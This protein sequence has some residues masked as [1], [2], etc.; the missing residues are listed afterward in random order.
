MTVDSTYS[1]PFLSVADQ[2]RRLRVRGMDCGDPHVA[3]LALERCGYYR[4]SGYW[5]TSR[6]WDSADGQPSYDEDGRERRRDEFVSGASLEHAVRVHDFDHDLR[7]RVLKVLETI[8][9]AFRFYIGHRAG[10]IDRFAH[11]RPE[12]LDALR[13]T[14]GGE[15]STPTTRYKEWREEYLREENR[16]RGQFVDHFRRRYG[17]SLPVWVATEV[18]SFGTLTRLYA[19][20]PRRDREVLAGRFQVLL[21]DGRED[22][23]TLGK[24]L[25]ALRLVRNICAHHGRL[26][27]RTLDRTL[28]VPGRWAAEAG[29]LE[30]VF[31]PGTVYNK[32]YHVLV[33]MRYLMLTI[34]P[35]DKRVLEITTFLEKEAAKSGVGLDQM[36]FPDGWQSQPLW[37]GACELSTSAGRAARILDRVDC[38]SKT[39]LKEWMATTRTW[40]P[41][42]HSGG[43]TKKTP[44]AELKSY[45]DYGA[46]LTVTLTTAPTFP[47][48]QF[49][50]GLIIAPAAEL[51]RRARELLHG[52][53]DLSQTERII[54]WWHRPHP[55][56]AGSAADLRS[57]R[58]LLEEMTDREFTEWSTANDVLRTLLSSC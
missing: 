21:G 34:D 48:F 25:S 11:L 6:E 56:T 51:H 53:D 47:R 52:D 35:Q 38:W 9:V 20:M 2:I 28:S 23:G 33:V 4:L 3:A 32:L 43:K 15:K 1:K 5:H 29:P 58:E 27:N 40:P 30:T 14:P 12:L 18:M 41:A 49:R 24:W 45:V 7:S 57:P 54:D 26:W 8:E 46:V 39:A 55:D 37:M 17:P 36:G 13:L 22:D 42:D 19:L 10:A 44:H 31:V 16:A 50:D